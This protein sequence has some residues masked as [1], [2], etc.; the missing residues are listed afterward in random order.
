MEKKMKTK[1]HPYEEFDRKRVAA[2]KK[3]NV[4]MRRGPF[5]KTNQAASSLAEAIHHADNISADH[6]GKECIIY[7]I[8][9]DG[10]TVHVDRA[11]IAAERA[12][13]AAA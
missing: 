7:A 10:M 4:H 12:A 5:D 9:H 13:I 8:T 2:A 1:V 3:F 6:G 11:T